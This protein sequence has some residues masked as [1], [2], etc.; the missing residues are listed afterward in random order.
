MTKREIYYLI[1][2]KH[3]RDGKFEADSYTLDIESAYQG[4]VP[5]KIT[6][7]D[8]VITVVFVDKSRHIF[9]YNESVE[10][11]D[12]LINEDNGK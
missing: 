10:Y 12:R 7:K 6:I 11:F 4:K 8:N 9:A 1:F 5:E 2:N 3:I